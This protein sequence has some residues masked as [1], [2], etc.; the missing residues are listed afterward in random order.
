MKFVLLDLDTSYFTRPEDLDRAY[1]PVWGKIPVHVGVVPFHSGQGV[2]VPLDADPS[3][4]YAISENRNLV[5]YLCSRIAA[6]HVYIFLHGFDHAPR[7]GRPEYSSSAKASE[8]I[9]IGCVALERSFGRRVRAFLPPNGGL[10]PEAMATLRRRGM[11]VIGR[12]SFNPIRMERDCRPENL[13]NWA[14][15]KYFLCRYRNLTFPWLL[16]S[17]GMGELDCLWLMPGDTVDKLLGFAERIRLI[18][19]TFCLAT[20]YWELNQNLEL[21]EVLHGF[22][23]RIKGDR[24][25]RFPFLDRIFNGVP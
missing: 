12:F 7:G 15:R 2:Y 23:D 11:H 9:E 4:L 22:I 24:G 17:G 18:R 3:R 19:G 16:R 10:C 13:W 20:H 14:R 25:I 1:G 5:D 21:R 6:G 8:R